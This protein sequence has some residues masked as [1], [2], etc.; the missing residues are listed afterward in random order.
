MDTANAKPVSV[1][2]YLA[3]NWLG[4]NEEHPALIVNPEA[5]P[6]DLLAWCWGEVASLESVT[7]TLSAAGANVSHGEL[8]AIFL[9]RL[10]PLAKVLET[11][12]DALDAPA[13]AERLRG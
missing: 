3:G 1:M 6:Q 4:I 2:G 8:S 10:T 13:R 12:I 5:S 7:Q 11:A 9:H